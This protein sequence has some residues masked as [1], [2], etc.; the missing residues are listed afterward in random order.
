MLA[1][2]FH[3]LVQKIAPNRLKKVKNQENNKYFIIKTAPNDFSFSRFGIIISQKVSKK[4]I[5]RN[6]IKRIIFNFIR[7]NN[8]HKLPGKDFLIIVLAPTNQL[9]KTIIEKELNLLI[10]NH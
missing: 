6:R 5:E 2:K 9:T 3:L 7:L 8:F 1:K 10:T 4:V